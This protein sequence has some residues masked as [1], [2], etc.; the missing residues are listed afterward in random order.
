M[1]LY[2]LHPTRYF[3][4]RLQATEDSYREEIAL[5]QLRLV[6]GALEESVL[7]TASDRYVS[8]SVS[9]SRYVKLVKINVFI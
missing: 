6:E 1:Q 3:E 7:K 5:L 2:T 9:K 4:Q 8:S